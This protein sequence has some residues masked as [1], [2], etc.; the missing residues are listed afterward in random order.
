MECDGFFDNDQH[1][2]RQPCDTIY[3]P[4][5]DTKSLL[6]ELYNGQ[7]AMAPPESFERDIEACLDA[8]YSGPGECIPIPL[9][10]DT[11][12]FDTIDWV[13]ALHS[14][15]SP[16]S[17]SASSNDRRSTPFSLTSDTTVDEASESLTQVSPTNDAQDGFAFS[18]E[19]ASMQV[20]SFDS[21]TSLISPDG[22]WR[23]QLQ[24]SS[25]GV[26]AAEVHG[27]RTGMMAQSS[28][29]SL[30]VPELSTQL[31]PAP[32][33]MYP[34]SLLSAQ[35]ALGKREPSDGAICKPMDER[36]TKRRRPQDTTPVHKC[37]KCPL[38]FARSHN[39]SVHIKDV[40]EGKRPFRCDVNGCPHA[41]K[42]K[43]DLTRHNQSKHTSRGSPRRKPPV[44]Q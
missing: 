16:S 2:L 26:G 22:H 13:S 43:H 10:S 14:A 24:H 34:P 28:S 33:R 30:Y 23:Q 9:P 11:F 29:L 5:I 8:A 38:T 15:S 12:V 36:P 18:F 35:S 40:H 6:E 21:P 20:S 41:F 4:T 32:S 42:R 25:G 7:I 44:Q 39:L 31:P 27:R 19:H 37:K 1:D 3:S 17:L